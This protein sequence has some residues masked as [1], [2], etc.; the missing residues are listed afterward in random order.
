MC[1]CCCPTRKSLLIYAIIVTGLTF[2]FGIITVALF[3]SSTDVHEFLVE[4]IDAIEESKSGSLSLSDY[5][6]L[7]S[8]YN[9]KDFSLSSQDAASMLAISTLSSQ[10]L[11]DKNYGVIK[12]LKGIENSFGVILFIISILLLGV[13]IYYLIFVLGIK[14]SQVLSEKMYNIMD[15]FKLVTYIVS[16]ASI[17]LSLLYG[18]LLIVAIA[19]YAGIINNIDSCSSGIICGIIYSF[20]SFWVYITLYVIFGKERQLF[21][22][23]GSATKPGTGAIYDLYG[24]LYVRTVISSQVVALNPQI[25][26]K[27]PLNYPYP[28]NVNV[29]IQQQQFGQIPSTQ[30]NLSNAIPNA[31]PNM[32]PNMQY[33]MQPNV[34]STIQPNMQINMQPNVQSYVQPNMQPNVQPNIQP[35]IQSNIQPNVQPNMQPNMQYNTQNNTNIK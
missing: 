3:G 18:I 11:E 10:Y 32:T 1:I 20:F 26:Q 13:E 29:N 7:L 17:F 19:Q 28:N 5:Y 23:V 14:E 30:R 9:S 27:P 31:Q 22:N 16:I 35:N 8:S 25:L 4:M 21:K 2:I 33:N 24:N 6:D 34:K 15:K 12:S